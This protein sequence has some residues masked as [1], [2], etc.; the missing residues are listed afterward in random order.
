MVSFVPEMKRTSEPAGRLCSVAAREDWFW[1]LVSGKETR[2]NGGFVCSDVVV[3]PSSRA[4]DLA[5]V[6]K[7]AARAP[8]LLPPRAGGDWSLLVSCA[9][10]VWKE[11]VRDFR[12]MFPL[13]MTR[14]L[15]SEKPAAKSCTA[16]VDRS[17]P[18]PWVKMRSGGE[19]GLPWRSHWMAFVLDRDFE[20]RSLVLMWSFFGIGVS[21]LGILLLCG[22]YCFFSLSFRHCKIGL[23]MKTQ[24]VCSVRCFGSRRK[25]LRGWQKDRTE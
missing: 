23:G 2:I 25:D 10:T 24:E 17:P 12:F 6:A 5:V 21:I 18:V 14:L 3:L 22:R 13:N 11:V 15:V 19:S 1:A 4:A 9:I 8:R 16:G 20:G 7:H